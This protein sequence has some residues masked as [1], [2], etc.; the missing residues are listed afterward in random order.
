MVRQ[1]QSLGKGRVGA[2]VE[3]Q[4]GSPGVGLPAQSLGDTW[5]APPQRPDHNIL[6]APDDLSSPRALA[7]WGREGSLEPPARGPC[8]CIGGSCRAVLGTAVSPVCE[9]EPR[10]THMDQV[11]Q[12]TGFHCPQDNTGGPSVGCQ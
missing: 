11:L 7:Q 9:G 10:G 8:L 3:G 5:L 12:Q 6:W 2:G 4:G 1:R